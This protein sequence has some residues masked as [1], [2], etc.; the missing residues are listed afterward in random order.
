MHGLR[1]A[2][3]VGLLLTAST[4][5]VSSADESRRWQDAISDYD[6]GRLERYEASRDKAWAQIEGWEWEINAEGQYDRHLTKETL[7][8]FVYAK[9][10]PI[11][12]EEIVGR[13]KCRTI[14]L[15][16]AVPPPEFLQ[17]FIYGWFDCRITKTKKGLM[18]RKLTGTVDPFGLL[19]PHTDD[20]LVFLG[21]ASYSSKAVVGYE[22]RNPGPNETCQTFRNEVGYLHRTGQDRYR[23]SWPESMCGAE[24]YVFELEPVP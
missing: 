4:A 16:T 2:M 10:R 20:E 14:H 7:R 24:F 11:S 19:Y 3:I 21:T 23:L 15:G 13:Y 1:L 17:F 8:N 6:R 12:A 9:P 22:K 5:P 18:F